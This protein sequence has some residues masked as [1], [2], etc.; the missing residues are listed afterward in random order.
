[1]PSQR[2]E[3]KSGASVMFFDNQRGFRS[4]VSTKGFDIHRELFRGC[5]ALFLSASFPSELCRAATG[6]TAYSVFFLVWTL[7]PCDLNNRRPGVPCFWICE[8]AAVVPV[9]PGGRP[10]L[11]RSV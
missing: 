7:G 4:S 10:T 2:G 8:R 5:P 1:M 3:T 9:K 11:N 6:G